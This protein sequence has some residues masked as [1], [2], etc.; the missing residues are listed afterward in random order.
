M[1]PTVCCCGCCQ[2]GVGLH[3]LGSPQTGLKGRVGHSLAIWHQPWHLKI[4]RE[5]GSLLLVVPSH[6]ALVP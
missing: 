3:S 1:G 6:L 2:E 5:L 4:W